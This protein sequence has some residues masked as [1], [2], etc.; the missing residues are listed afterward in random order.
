MVVVV[1]KVE[2]TPGLR[3]WVV[4]PSSAEREAALTQPLPASPQHT[5]SLRYL[6]IVG[7]SQVGWMKVLAKFIKKGDIVL[8]LLKTATS[9]F[10][11]ESVQFI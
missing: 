10:E 5:F 11:S 1:V 3:R 4:A 9:F 6:H 7:F 8:F 2:V